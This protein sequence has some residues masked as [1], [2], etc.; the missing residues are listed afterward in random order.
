MRCRSLHALALQATA[1]GPYVAASAGFE[2]TTFSAKGIDSINTTF[3]FSASPAP[4]ANSAVLNKLTVHFRWKIRRIKVYD[5]F[6]KKI[7]ESYSYLFE[8]EVPL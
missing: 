1:Q 7:S 5:L 2:P 3:E 8:P 4:L 6:I